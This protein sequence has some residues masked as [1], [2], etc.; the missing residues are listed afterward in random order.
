MQRRRE[1]RRGE[2]SAKMDPF[3]ERL[4]EIISVHEACMS[5]TCGACT[6]NMVCTQC[7]CATRGCECVYLCVGLPA[8]AHLLEAENTHGAC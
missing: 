1:E 7:A 4:S 6:Y 8:A 2:N 5:V 3:E